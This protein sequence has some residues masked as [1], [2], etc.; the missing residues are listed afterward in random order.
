MKKFT[1]MLAF[2]TTVCLF[3][4][5]RQDYSLEIKEGFELGEIQKTVNPDQTLT[6]T[7]A[8]TSLANALNAKQIYLFEKAFPIKNIRVSQSIPI[9]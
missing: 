6:L 1:L 5:Y 4:Q 8:N 3:S 2:L 9:R 7:M